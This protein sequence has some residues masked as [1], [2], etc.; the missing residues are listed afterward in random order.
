MTCY[1][2]LLMCALAA[3]CS[4]SDDAPERSFAGVF[5][6]RFPATPSEQN[7]AG[8]RTTVRCRSKT[9]GVECQ[10]VVRRTQNSPIKH[11]NDLG[12]DGACAEL[13]AWMRQGVSAL[14]GSVLRSRTYKRQGYPACEGTLQ[15]PGAARPAKF[16][17][18]VTPSHFVFALVGCVN[19]EAERQYA[20][21]FL[22]S[23]RICGS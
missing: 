3:A 12:L 21:P 1:R 16:L 10:V 5:A 9:L 19:D 23:I 7:V 17:A 11:L 8:D 6:A 20:R 4:S 13:D 15:L 2:I 14:E 22:D 18:I